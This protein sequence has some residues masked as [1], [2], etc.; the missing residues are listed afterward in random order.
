MQKLLGENIHTQLIS[1]ALG[2]TADVA[3][4]VQDEINNTYQF[5]WS[6]ASQEEIYF[7]SHVAFETLNVTHSF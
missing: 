4:R 7:I 3:L 2:V 6:E 1:D 5:D